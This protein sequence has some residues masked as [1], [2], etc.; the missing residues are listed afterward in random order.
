MPRWSRAPS[1]R[2]EAATRLEISARLL[3][4]ASGSQRA[5]TST[6]RTMSSVTGSYAETGRSSSKAVVVLPTCAETSPT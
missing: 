1:G 6:G 4:A 2:S 3:I 5:G